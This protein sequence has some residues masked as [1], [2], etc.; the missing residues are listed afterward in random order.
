[1]EDENLL[2][3]NIELDYVASACLQMLK[4]G[5]LLKQLDRRCPSHVKEK[6]KYFIDQATC[7]KNCYRYTG[8]I[9]SKLDLVFEF[10]ESKLTEIRLGR[11]SKN[12]KKSSKN[13][14]L[15]RTREGVDVNF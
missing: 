5:F 15:V 10:L 1:M 7:P 9:M 2:K 3:E 14:T 13:L 11:G 8:V 6:R 4:L 12:T